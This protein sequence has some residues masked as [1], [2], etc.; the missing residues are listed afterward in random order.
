[1]FHKL[2]FLEPSGSAND[3]RELYCKGKY[4]EVYFLSI[5][6]II[7]PGEKSLGAK[8]KPFPNGSGRLP[9]AHFS[10][11]GCCSS[12]DLTQSSVRTE[13]LA[14]SGCHFLEGL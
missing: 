13:Q 7:H 1:V 9:G 2:C 3:E 12:R 6:G 4:S 5:P 14:Q 11:T 8:E 10:N